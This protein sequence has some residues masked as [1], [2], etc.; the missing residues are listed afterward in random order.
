M[1]TPT[2]TASRSSWPFAAS[3]PSWASRTVPSATC[4]HRSSREAPPSSSSSSRCRVHTVPWSEPRAARSQP[5]LTPNPPLGSAPSRPPAPMYVN[6]YTVKKTDLSQ[7][8]S[9]W[10]GGRTRKEEEKEIFSFTTLGQKQGELWRLDFC[11]TPI[12]HGHFRTP[13]TPH[14]PLIFHSESYK[15]KIF[16]SLCQNWRY[17]KLYILSNCELSGKSFNHIN[18]APIAN[19]FTVITS[20]YYVSKDTIVCRNKQKSLWTSHLLLLPSF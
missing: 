14:P 19:V 9:G 10:G 16:P 12:C 20:I 11:V 18:H 5:Y 7:S 17:I 15:R 6:P 13:A 4:R 2:C 3:C 8:V 1:T